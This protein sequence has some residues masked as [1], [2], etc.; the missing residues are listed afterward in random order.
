M[1]P[2]EEI[3]ELLG[4]KPY[5]VP[6]K[7][8]TKTPE[9]A[10]VQRPYAETL[11]RAYRALLVDQR[12]DG[13]PNLAIYLGAASSGLCAIDFDKEEHLK[14]FLAVN[15]RL[16]TTLQSKAARGAQVWV[17]IV[18]A[19]PESMSCAFYEWRADKRLSTIHGVHPSGKKY[20]LL[21]KAPPVELAFS[22]IH[23]PDGWPK[24]GDDERQRRFVEA[25]G[26]PWLAGKDGAPTR[27]NQRHYAARLADT[28]D[29]LFDAEACRFYQYQADAGVWQEETEDMVAD[30]I[31]RLVNSDLREAIRVNV[32]AL[33]DPLGRGFSL[34]TNQF[35]HGAAGQLRG[36]VG[37]RKRFQKPRGYIHCRN[38]ILDLTERPFALKPFS[39][40]L[41][42]RNL[43]PV[44]YDPA[45][46]C[47]RFVEELLAPQL[48]ADD[49]HLLQLCAGQYLLG[50]NLFQ[51]FL[52]V[53]GTAGGGKSTICKLLARMIGRQNVHELRTGELTGRFEIGMYIGKTLLYGPDAEPNFLSDVGAHRIKALT[54]GDYLTGEIKGSSIPVEIEGD[55]NMLISSNSELHARLRGDSA[56]WAR[57]MLI[58]RFEK[59]P[60]AKPLPEFDRVLFETEGPGILNWMLA[61]AVEVM[62]CAEQR[63]PLPIT[64]EQR[65]RTDTLLAECDSV[66]EFVRLRVRKSNLLADVLTNDQLRAAYDQTCD[67]HGWQPAK[68]REFWTR[69]AEILSTEYRASHDKHLG[70]NRSERGWRGL[71]L[72]DDATSPESY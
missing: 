51:N 48:D 17:K 10:Y 22:D 28:G 50:R 40:E 46:T 37:C 15:D 49:Q 5:W 41:Y 62:H 55:F 13:G 65:K 44:A 35:N 52:V 33:A 1:K 60:P 63:V 3:E 61:G 20:R 54:G 26:E 2:H 6:V 66:R 38:G 32:E 36:M 21:V 30:A 45:A 57:R 4:F 9:L 25:N 11:D 24:P 59:P 58:I 43:T 42:S 7:R 27:L 19:Y 72:V 18:G 68:P 8:G 29:W 70:P 39:R 71:V 69:L 67:D 47:P 31:G 53:T 16:L 12:G 34:I 23:W 56:A 14:A 64:D